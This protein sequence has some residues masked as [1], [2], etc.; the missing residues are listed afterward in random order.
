MLTRSLPLAL[1]LA[2][3]LCGRSSPAQQPPPGTPF[4]PG[5]VLATLKDLKARQLAVV[6]RER[7]NVTANINAAIA[8]PA[9]F[10]ELAAAAV[11]FQNGAR[12]DA[13]RLNEWRKRHGAELRNRDFVDALRQ[14]LVYLSLTWQHSA[15]TKT[16]DLVGP[17]LDHVALVGRNAEIYSQFDIYHRSLGESVFVPYFQIGP[18]I[19]GLKDWSD[20]PFDVDSIYDKT[21]FPELRAEKNPRLFDCWKDRIQ[22]ETT[23]ASAGQN[24]LAVNKFNN[25]RLPTL[26]WERAEDEFVFGLTNQAV[27]DMLGL[28]KAHPD[29]PD[30]DHWVARLTEIVA[31]PKAEAAAGPGTAATPTPTP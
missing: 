4:D 7:A 17:L 19:N 10:Y 21:I 15:G 29:H 1:L 5:A 8:D 22:L 25:V 11:E 31:P 13:T 24:P 28:I 2:T 9:K 26:L 18:Y 23:R 20:R 27:G 12:D 16:R 14:H 30:F 3:L 6:N